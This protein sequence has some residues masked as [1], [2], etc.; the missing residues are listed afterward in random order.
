MSNIIRLQE[1]KLIKETKKILEPYKAK[2]RAMNDA[3]KIK[4][5]FNIITETQLYPNHIMTLIKCKIFIRYFNI[6]ALDLETKQ[7]VRQVNTECNRTIMGR[8][9]VNYG[10]QEEV[11]PA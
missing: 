11:T 7:L 8:L 4:E 6:S 2:V 3:D 9:Y 1:Y 10:I 5:F